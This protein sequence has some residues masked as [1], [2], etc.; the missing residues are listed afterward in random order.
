MTL[1]PSHD[2][3]HRPIRQALRALRSA[4]TSMGNQT[5]QQLM[6]QDQQQA[7]ATATTTGTPTP[8]AAE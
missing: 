3:M 8:A 4:N 5:D 7:T 2:P 1:F 6:A